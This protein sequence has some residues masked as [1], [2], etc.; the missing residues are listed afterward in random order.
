MTMPITD[1]TNIAMWGITG[2][3]KTWMLHA[4]AKELAWYNENDP[5][6]TYTLLD[7]NNRALALPNPPDATDLAPTEMPE[8]RTWMFERKGRDSASRRHL[9]SSHVH[10]IV[11]HDNRGSDLVDVVS[12]NENENAIIL[13]VLQASSNLIVTLDPTAVEDAPLIGPVKSQQQYKKYEYEQ[14]IRGLVNRIL[15]RNNTGRLAICLSK[16]DLVRLYLPVEKIIEALY[17]EG[18]ARALTNPKLTVRFFRVSS[19][20]TVRLSD[21]RRVTNI[22]DGLN[23]LKVPEKWDPVNVVSPFFWLFEEIERARIKSGSDFLGDRVSQYIPYPQPR[24]A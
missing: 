5:Q 12:K 15:E 23:V 3:G 8:D 1:D 24:P 20:G 18:F 10:R 22:S 4:F 16:A 14:F 19:V 11:V 21:G 2:S 6:F 9:I 7:G 13:S 17:G